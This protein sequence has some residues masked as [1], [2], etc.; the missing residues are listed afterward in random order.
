[1]AEDL[2]PA[3]RSNDPHVLRTRLAY[4]RGRALSA[5]SLV[6][7]LRQQYAELAETV[8]D[9]KLKITGESP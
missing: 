5:E 3:D 1:M 4:W 8:Q 7:Q 6:P 2:D 9:L